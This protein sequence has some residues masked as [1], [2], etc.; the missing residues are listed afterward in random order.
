MKPAPTTFRP[1]SRAQSSFLLA[2]IAVLHGLSFF[3]LLFRPAW[4][5]ERASK[6]SMIGPFPIPHSHHITSYQHQRQNDFND[7]NHTIHE[8]STFLDP[9]RRDEVSF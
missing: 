5:N 4:S 1:T 3:F 9:W 6:R 7:P 8:A 2:A